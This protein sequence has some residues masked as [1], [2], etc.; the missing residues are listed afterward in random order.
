VA[1]VTRF[2]RTAGVTA[3]RGRHELYRTTR[4]IGKAVSEARV[5]TGEATLRRLESLLAESKDLRE[6]ESSVLSL[7]ADLFAQIEGRPE[8]RNRVVVER[9]RHMDEELSLD[10]VSAAVS[11]S[12]SYLS[13][14]FKEGS[15]V[16]FV[17]YVTEARILEAERLL[18][19]SQAT[20]QEIGKLVGFNTPAYFIHQFRT[21]FGAT[22]YEFRRNLPSRE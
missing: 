5:T 22:P 15:G 10:R 17:A 12:P 7:A 13:K 14:V 20:I 2:V 6:W 21:R 8:D 16:N 3:D 11:I 1:A 9:V 4:A 19:Q 18:R